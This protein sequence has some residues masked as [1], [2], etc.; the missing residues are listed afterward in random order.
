ML[1]KS[2][3]VSIVAV[4]AVG[5]FTF[6]LFKLTILRL[7]NMKLASRKN[8]MS[9][10]GII[11]IRA[12]DSDECF[13]PSLTGMMQSSLQFRCRYRYAL[14]L[15]A[16]RPRAGKCLQIVSVM[17]RRFDEQ[18]HVVDCLLQTSAKPRQPPIEKIVGQQAENSRTQATG[19]GDQRFRDTAAYFHS[20]K[21]LLADKAERPHDAGDGAQQP[22]QRRKRDQR[23]EHPDILFPFLNFVIGPQ[24]HR[25]QHR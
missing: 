13:G 4:V 19:C 10:S 2:F 7:T 15:G 1:A 5:R 6:T 16:P 22:Q 24:L 18:F 11:S 17:L 20:S 12:S 8:M 3:F 21:F 14:G 23:S 25:A 9:I